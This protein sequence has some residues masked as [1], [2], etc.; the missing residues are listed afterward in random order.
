MSKSR[1]NRFESMEDFAA[2]VSGSATPRSGARPGVWVGALLVAAAITGGALWMRNREW[3][4]PGR[5]DASTSAPAPRVQVR[6]DVRS[7]PTAVLHVDGRRIGL[8]PIEDGRL[9]VGVHELRLERTG[10]RAVVDTVT[11]TAERGVRRSYVLRR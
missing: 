5:T 10:Y 9:S 8:T 6:F 3:H 1:S 7:S 2:A 4:L 11:V